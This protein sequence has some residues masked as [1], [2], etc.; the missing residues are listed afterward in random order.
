MKCFFNK[1][2]I[3]IIYVLKIFVVENKIYFVSWRWS[4][5]ESLGRCLRIEDSV[6]KVLKWGLIDNLGFYIIYDFIMLF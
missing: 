3:R 4:L 5:R 6:I 2:Y 1:D